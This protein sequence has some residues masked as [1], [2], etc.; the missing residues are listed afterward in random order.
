VEVVA[1]MSSPP[2]KVFVSYSRKDE[3]H[4]LDLREHLG[5]LVRDR[6]F[7]LWVDRE[8][9]PGSQWHQETFRTLAEAD[10]VLLLMSP[11]Y[12]SSE[13]CMLEGEL[14]MARLR[15]GQVRVIPILIRHV[16]WMS[17]PFAELQCLP[18]GA[19]VPEFGA[20]RDLTF[21]RISQV[22]RQVA[23]EVQRS[24]K[25]RS[26]PRAGQSSA[27]PDSQ[28][29]LERMNDTALTLAEY[30]GEPKAALEMLERALALCRC[31]AGEESDDYAV[32]LANRGQALQDLGDLEGARKDFERALAISEERHGRRHPDMALRLTHLGG[33][34]LELREEGEAKPLLEEAIVLLE[35]LP[36]EAGALARAKIFLAGALG[37]LGEFR[38]A[39]ALLQ[40]VLAEQ[41]QDP[42]VAAAAY[43]ALGRIAQQARR[44]REARS[45]FSRALEVE[46]ETYG[47]HHPFVAVDLCNLGLVLQSL[48]RSR[49]ADMPFCR[50][51]EILTSKLGTDSPR[52]SW[53]GEGI[54]LLAA[55]RS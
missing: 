37:S 18:G 32:L 28:E 15:T 11:A 47:S 5:G 48:G 3:T 17:S 41:S 43:S 27:E 4:L 6:V 12:L 10:I 16:D 46:R 54:K 23:D 20:A 21:T 9:S 49:S 19:P 52:V 7:D 33:V 34:L 8:I 30:G 44:L 42:K 36:H 55:E 31:R 45:Y 39:K 38:E 53:A 29:E 22:L 2:L 40:K 26:A 25:E 13:F 1:D 14:A 35:A 24:R 51:L 50:C